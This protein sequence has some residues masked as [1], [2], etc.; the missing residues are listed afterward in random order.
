MT[1]SQGTHLLKKIYLEF[2]S[3]SEILSYN[4]SA[5]FLNLAFKSYFRLTCKSGLRVMLLAVL[6]LPLYPLS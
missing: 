4:F 6:S 1:G 5:L 3:D 2:G